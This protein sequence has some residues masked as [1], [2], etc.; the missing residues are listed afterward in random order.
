MNRKLRA[1]ATVSA[2]SMAATLSTPVFAQAVGTASGTSVENT[3]TVQFQVDNIDQTEVTD[4]NEFLVDRKIDLTVTGDGSVQSRAPGADGSPVLVTSPFTTFDVTNTSNATLDFDLSATD[5][6]AGVT[7]PGGGA[8]N[9]VTSGFQFFLDDG[10]AG[11]DPATDLPITSLDDVPSGDTRTVYVV[12]DIPNTTTNGDFGGVVLTATA[13]ETDGTAITASPTNVADDPNAVETVFA[14]G[15]G[16]TD[17]D[18]DGAFSAIDGFQVAAA[19]LSVVKSSTVIWDPISGNA[20]PKAIPGAVVE[21]CI[22]VTNAAGG[23]DATGVTIS[24]DLTIASINNGI[25]FYDVAATGAGTV[26]TANFLVA[27]DDCVPTNTLANGETVTE[28]SDVITGNLGTVAAGDTE[29]VLF[30][31]IVN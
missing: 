24:D 21:Y 31:A 12:A 16:A 29:T 2:I 18:R 9:F 15:A 1:L 8:D 23:A 13:L 5:L 20:N 14:D 6:T 17:G 7:V 25:Q 30:R 27:G 22:A 3:V 11:F 19:A 10:V 4:S 26:P 28:A